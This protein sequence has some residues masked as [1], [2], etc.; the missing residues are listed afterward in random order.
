MQIRSIILLLFF[1]VVPICAQFV[2]DKTLSATK[3]SNHYS[4]QFLRL[5]QI[6]YGN[7]EII[8]QGGY[9]SVDILFANID[10]HNQKVLDI[11]SGFGGVD[12]YLAEKFY[13]EIVGV[14]MEP[15]MVSMAEKFLD[16]HKK[17]LKGKVSFLT[18][19]NPCKLDPF[20][21]ETFD[22]IFSK[23]T[24]YNIPRSEK[25]NYLAE[26][27]RKLKPGGT[28]IIADWF[29]RDTIPGEILD[30]AS[31]DKK[32]C[33][34]VTPETFASM[35][36]NTHFQDI[37]WQDHSAEHIRYT[38]NECQ[39]IKCHE[40]TISEQFGEETYHKTVRNWK[41]WLEAQ[42]AGELLSVTF[43]AKKSQ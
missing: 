2:P 37:E 11:G 20:V 4:P 18:L 34:F 13:F 21:D 24:F 33:Q 9:E 14:D 42:Q 10:F 29:Q 36:K 40:A 22:L 25:Q 17:T 41:Y 28:L 23:E 6:A 16:R 30:K 31:T 38:E 1:W 32:A 43:F 39:R 27:Y 35:L 15:Y 19:E 8:S 5:L 12:I 26:A 7:E 3:L